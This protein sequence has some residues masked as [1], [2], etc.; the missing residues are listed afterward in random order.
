MLHNLVV[1]IVGNLFWLL[2][3]ILPTPFLSSPLICLLAE[4]G[5]VV[6]ID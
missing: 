1:F 2:C 6:G 4:A 5:G 3:T